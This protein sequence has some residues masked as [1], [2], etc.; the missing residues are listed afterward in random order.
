VLEFIEENLLKA[1]LNAFI[2]SIIGGF[3]IR[4][5][6]MK[7]IKCYWRY[8]KNLKLIRYELD[9][10]YKKSLGLNMRNSYDCFSLENF[11]M[12]S[13]N[14]NVC[15]EFLADIQDRIDRYHYIQ[16][17]AQHLFT[18]ENINKKEEYRNIIKIGKNTYYFLGDNHKPKPCFC[19]YE[20]IISLQTI[21]EEKLE[22]LKKP[23]SKLRIIGI[24]FKCR[25]PKDKFIKSFK[26]S[27]KIQDDE[28]KKKKEVRKLF[29]SK[30]KNIMAANK[31]FMSE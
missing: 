23:K 31:Y 6:L 1:L 3:L 2:G 10:L 12:Y 25:N 14:E 18:G 29:K 30:F 8:Q 28:N 22:V 24:A 17:E 19:L 7:R 4:C 20:S 13:L 15:F 16:H 26:D 5:L 21:L 27:F 11:N 9:I